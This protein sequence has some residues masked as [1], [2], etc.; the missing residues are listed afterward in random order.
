MIAE[1]LGVSL[2]IVPTA[3]TSAE[4]S[5]VRSAKQLPKESMP[6]QSLKSFVHY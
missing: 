1:V 6:C 2:G 3:P 5:V 4:K